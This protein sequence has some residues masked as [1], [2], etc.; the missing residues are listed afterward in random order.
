MLASWGS[1]R[2]FRQY[3]ANL[4]PS[5]SN[6]QRATP[7]SARFSLLL[8][9]PAPRSI[10]SSHCCASVV[11]I[12]TRTTGA[13]GPHRFGRTS[14]RSAVCPDLRGCSRRAT[15][16]Q[17]RPLLRRSCHALCRRGN[18]GAPQTVR[19]GARSATRA[20]LDSCGWRKTTSAFWRQGG[21][22]GSPWRYTGDDRR[23]RQRARVVILQ[24]KV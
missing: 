24:R 11:I 3:A 23:V 13:K 18:L 17:Q 4:R 20:Q 9:P 5:M 1:Q 2:E 8:V 15:R 10:A 6:P 21:E 12:A 7:Y 19:G 14:P 22:R 16:P